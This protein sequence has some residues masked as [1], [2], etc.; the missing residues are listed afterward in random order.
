MRTSWSPLWPMA[1]LLVPPL[2][3]N[4]VPAFAFHGAG[5]G[6]INRWVVQVDLMILR[7]FNDVSDL[8]ACPQFSPS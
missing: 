6:L 8:P 5:N 4:R 2:R 7:G 3:F 1:A